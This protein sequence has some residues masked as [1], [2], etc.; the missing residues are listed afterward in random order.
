EVLLD[1]SKVRDV[2]LDYRL[3]LVGLG[4]A[5]TGLGIL[6]VTEFVP[7]ELADVGVI[8]EDTRPPRR[9]A[10]DGRS[11]PAPAARTGNTIPVQ[12]QRDGPRRLTRCIF[13]KDPAD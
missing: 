1:D 3:G 5:L 10:I 4:A 6:H 9:I 2:L 11:A 12:S 8:V 7:D 13:A